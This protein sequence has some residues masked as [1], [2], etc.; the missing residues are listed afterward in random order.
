MPP[1][2]RVTSVM[3]AIF[4]QVFMSVLIPKSFDALLVDVSSNERAFRRI[5]S[6]QLLFFRPLK[7]A[8]LLV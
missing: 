3:M 2:A 6:S 5:A 8:G 4:C 7:R 1:M